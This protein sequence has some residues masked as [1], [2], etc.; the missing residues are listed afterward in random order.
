[1]LLDSTI[2]ELPVCEWPA[3]PSCMSKHGAGAMPHAVA[4]ARGVER[5]VFFA[6]EGRPEAEPGSDAPAPAAVV[7]AVPVVLLA[8]QGTRLDSGDCHRCVHNR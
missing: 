6:M 8:D 5:N 7:R 2:G 1:M 3:L 4:F